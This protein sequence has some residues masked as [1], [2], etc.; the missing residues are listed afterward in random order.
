MCKDSREAGLTKCEACN[1]DFCV[2][3]K[4][5]RPLVTG[6]I[7]P[8]GCAGHACE[9]DWF[10]SEADFPKL[11]PG[12]PKRPARTATR[13]KAKIVVADSDTVCNRS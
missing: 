10:A 7:L 13:K 11:A 4:S 8:H 12:A 3:H 9:D 1:D 2:V 5:R 6:V